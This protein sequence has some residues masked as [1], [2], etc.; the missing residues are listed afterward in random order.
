MKY[1]LHLRASNVEAYA[2]TTEA[3]DIKKTLIDYGIDVDV[4]AAA[5][6]VEGEFLQKYWYDNHKE[7]KIARMDNGRYMYFVCYGKN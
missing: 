6:N 1:Y 3:L 2:D 7:A 4:R 5:V